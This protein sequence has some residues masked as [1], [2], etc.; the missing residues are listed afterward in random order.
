MH[1][2]LYRSAWCW[3]YY[4]VIVRAAVSAKPIR[5]INP[6]V[7]ARRRCDFSPVTQKMG[8]KHESHV[9]HRQR[10]GANA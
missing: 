2:L 7:A 10:P 3:L 1:E 6:F 5:V 8:G 4:R 9:R